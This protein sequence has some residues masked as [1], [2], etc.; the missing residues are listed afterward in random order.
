MNFVNALYSLVLNRA[1]S[2]NEETFWINQ[3]DTA[4]IASVV[5]NIVNSDESYRLI[6]TNDY[7]TYLNRTA[8]A[9]GRDFWANQLR[10]NGGNIELVAEN[11]LATAEYF[12]LAAK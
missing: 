2:Q 11:F 10:A 3:I 12:A 5:S 6:A 4:G 1:P 9:A 8:D 7:M